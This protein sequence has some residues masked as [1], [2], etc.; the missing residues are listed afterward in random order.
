MIIALDAMGGD[1]APKEPIKGALLANRELDM[2]IALVGSSE[3]IRQ[4][5]S[6]HGPVPSGIEIVEASEAIGMEETPVQAVRQKKDA[7]INVAMGLVKRGTAS[8][9]V[10]AGNTGAV[11]ASA[12]LNLGRVP[13]IERPAIGT[14]A[15]YTEKGI[16][17]LDVGANADCK[18]SYLIQFAQMGSL[19]MEKV[20][21]IERPRV[22][23]LNIGEEPSKGNELTQEVFEQLSRGNLNFVG[24]IE[25]DRVHRG[26]AEVIVTDGFT[27]NIAVKV[28]EGTADFIFGELRTAI[29]S[30]L[31]YK[32]AG[33]VMRPALLAMRRR[34]DYSEYG[35]APLLGVNGVVTIAH[36]RADDNA[37]KNAL[38]LAR[39]VVESGMLQTLRDAF[40]REARAEAAAAASESRA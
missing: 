36:G 34:L 4:E 12:L 10:S 17:V 33:L 5:L 31:H 11:M 16:L 38:R 26:L 22:G 35:G 23:L 19:Y 14:I 8:A 1:L 21:G 13:G 27:G 3:L 2:Q 37:M 32:L 9:V 18:P 7:S 28:T 25:P 15:P 29:T 39:H 20:A 6:H 30:K 24:N 40:G